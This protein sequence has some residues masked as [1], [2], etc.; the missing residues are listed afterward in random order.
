[1]IDYDPHDWR[2]HLLDIKG[3]MVKQI[4]Y[5]VALCVAWSVVVVY[6]YE[7]HG[8][9]QLAISEKGHVLIGVAL[10]LLLV[11]RTN[12]S[13]D[14]FWEGRTQ[15]GAI[16]NETRNLARLAVTWLTEADDL[17]RRL[18][19]W[20]I[21]FAYATMHSL[22]G[23]RG[24]GPAAQWLPAGEVEAVLAADQG[25]LAVACKMTEVLVEVRR[26]GLLSDQALRWFE[27]NVQALVDYMGACERIQ[28]TPLPFVYMVHLRR[29]LI[30]YCFTLP[31]ALLS[32]FG[33]GTA[34]ATLL[35]SYTL[36]GIEEIGVEIESPFGFD[37]NDLPL[38]RFCATI[39]RDLL[40]LLQTP[41]GGTP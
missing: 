33:W 37:D 22:R 15:W 39:E 6:V 7:V 5:R 1:M 13:Y 17:R 12:S 23:N 34:L 11:F 19:H 41:A 24:V 40:A 26:R 20:T 27:L 30:L 2:H 16:I 4:F 36:Y 10:G 25:P 29:A 28:K 31:F 32:A 38:E 14:R 18:V 21:G 3:S 9:E 35:I 8:V